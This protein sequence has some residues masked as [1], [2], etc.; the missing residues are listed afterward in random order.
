MQA[1]LG[2]PIMGVRHS[3]LQAYEKKLKCTICYL[4]IGLSI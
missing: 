2:D 4:N 1:G 3:D